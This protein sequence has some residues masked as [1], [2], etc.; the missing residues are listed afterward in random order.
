MPSV[1]AW[2]FCACTAIRAATEVGSG[3]PAANP[4]AGITDTGRIPRNPAAKR[5]YS[6]WPPTNDGRQTRLGAAGP[7]HTGTR[8]GMLAR[9]PGPVKAGRNAARSRTSRMSCGAR[10]VRVAWA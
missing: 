5:A 4:G 10:P 8:R 9:S 6:R 2:M 3:S 1:Q 7:W